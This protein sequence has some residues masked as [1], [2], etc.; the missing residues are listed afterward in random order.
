MTG[1]PR[2][3]RFARLECE[4]RF[5]LAAA[6]PGLPAT[7]RLITDRY[8]TGTR[9]RLRRVESPGGE[10]EFKLTQKIPAERSGP[11]QGLITTVYLTAAEYAV[12]ARLPARVLRKTRYGLPPLGVDVF[13]PP[14]AG[15]VLA[16]AE[17]DTA[18]AA[19]AFPVPD[20][21]V[22][23]VT[24]DPRF[25][26]GSLAATADARPNGDPR[27]NGDTRLAGETQLARWLAEFG[28]RAGAAAE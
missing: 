28:I 19:A 10:P 4:R 24:A 9:M 16:E 5:L 8:L 26:G 17:F 1:A 6:P 23:E 14:L 2:A 11:V 22:A 18:D 7:G 12:F 20:F 25:T 21:A 27:P 13:G 3:G 15:L